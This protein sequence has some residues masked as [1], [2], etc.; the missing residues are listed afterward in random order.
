ML[1]KIIYILTSLW[2]ISYSIAQ[3]FS[4][5]VILLNVYAPKQ[6]TIHAAF[7]QDGDLFEK[8]SVKF[9]AISPEMYLKMR[10]C[11]FFLLVCYS[12][13]PQ[14]IKFQFAMHDF[15]ISFKDCINNVNC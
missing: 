11:F 4:V 10:Y 14:F 13:R 12:P 6:P 5:H 9:E 8:K 15:F 1:E 3:I 2:N 7:N